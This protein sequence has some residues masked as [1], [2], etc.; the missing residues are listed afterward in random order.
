MAMLSKTQI[1]INS[2]ELPYFSKCI[3]QQEIGTHHIMDLQCLLETIERFCETTN[4]QIED[5][6]GAPIT[7]ETT[8]YADL[9]FFG[10]LK[11]KGIIT[12][13]NFKKGVYASDGNHVLITAKSPTILCDDGPHNTS[14]SDMSFVDIMQQNFNNYDR[15]K[16]KINTQNSNLTTPLAYTVQSNQSC[17]NFAQQMAARH[18][19]WL[20]YNGEELVFGLNPNDKE[21]ELKLGRDLQDLKTSLSPLPQNFNYYT[22]NYLVDE[23]HEKPSTSVNASNKDYF[24]V[25]NSNAKDLYSNQTKVWV[26]IPDD[27]Q[28]KNNLNTAV[29]LQQEAIESN[30]IKITASSDNPGVM[31]TN[32]VSVLKSHYRVTKV[33]HSYSNT[34]EYKNVFEASSLNVNAYPKTNINAIP[35]SETQLAKV[36]ENADPEGLGRIK[37][38]FAWQ[39]S[40]GLTTPWIR[41]VSPHTG[42]DKG[43]HFI[44]EIGEE[45]LIGFEGGHAEKPYM[46]GSLYHSNQ[47]PS[48]WKTNSNDIKAIRTRSGHTIELNDAKGEES[49]TITDINGNI[50]NIDTASN[51]I[52]ITALENMTLNSKNMQINVEENLDISVGKN[53]TETINENN[54]ITSGN[55]DKQVGEAI[56]VISA[57]YKQ[58]AQEITTEASGEIKTNAGGKITIASGETVEYGE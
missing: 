56:K 43:F 54:K 23:V 39:K 14:Y 19:E 38:E 1:N 8:S 4:Q 42:N 11:F 26:N 58:E 37:V 24:S 47:K 35:K 29:K 46:L 20:Y 36:T 57:T 28:S 55:E 52:T 15:S 7:I 5:L 31:L 12:D 13:L 30:Q 21:I 22:N 6:L 44:P 50:V 33:T 17:F 53:K 49:I 40:I 27:N 10:T 25:V 32:V 45:V 9:G 16:L 51:N 41:I 18:G 3:L 2:S 48:S 34:G